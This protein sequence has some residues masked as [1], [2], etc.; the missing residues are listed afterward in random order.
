MLENDGIYIQSPAGLA[1]WYVCV[2]SAVFS[3]LGFLGSFTSVP[4]TVDDC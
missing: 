4:W 1:P 3:Q 2:G